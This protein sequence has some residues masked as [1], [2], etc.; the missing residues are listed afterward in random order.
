M[1][2]EE[3]GEALMPSIRRVIAYSGLDYHRV[4]ELPCDLFLLMSKNALVDELNRTEGGREY[5]EKCRRLSV[6]GLDTAAF[7]R[8]MRGG[9]TDGN[10]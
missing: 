4:L 1:A 7:A 3:D 5:L 6:T 8:R 2:V 9:G 10:A